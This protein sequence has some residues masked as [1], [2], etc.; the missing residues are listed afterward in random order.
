MVKILYILSILI[1]ILSIIF[2]TILIM[3]LMYLM[4]KFLKLKKIKKSYSK[5][6]QKKADTILFKLSNV[7]YEKI[8][9]I[10]NENNSIYHIKQKLF[11]ILEN[12]NIKNMIIDVDNTDLTITQVEELKDIFKKLNEC[13]TV[14]AIGSIYTNETYQIAMLAKNIYLESTVNSTLFLKG[15][16][17]KRGYYKKFFEKIGINF[18]VMH[19]GNFKSAYENFQKTEMSPET[20][21]NLKMLL[22]KNLDYFISEVKE[23]RLVDIKQDLLDGK[24]IYEVE[25]ND[26]IDKRVNKEKFIKSFEN[27]IEFSEYKIKRKKTKT[28]NKIGIIS[29]EGTIKSGELS[30]NYVKNKISQLKD[31]NICGLVLEINSPGGSAYESNVIYEYIKDN[32]NV[33]IFVS[34][35]DVCASGGYMIASVGKKLYAN[36][37]TLTGSIGVVSMA[38]E[39]KKLAEKLGINYDGLSLGKYSNFFDIFSDIDEERK[40]INIK[41][42]EKVYYEFKKI[43]MKCRHMTDARLETLAQGKVYYGEMANDVDLIDGIANLEQTINYLAKYLELDDYD[44]V[45]TSSKETVKDYIYSKLG[46]KIIESIKNLI[47]YKLKI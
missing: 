11:N 30:L 17:L 22:D 33:P 40:N 14:Y 39:L 21:Q 38:F 1:S 18:E 7:S 25:N 8:N 12:T 10:L 34:M 15:Y 23:N 24:F 27:I 46:L 42:M 47:E 36:K 45:L 20:K 37:T 44:V 19:V 29:L 35:K 31:E 4:Y 16:N 32:I 3:F 9:G 43:V 41:H 2:I 13:K 28:K 5:V 26:L 6:S